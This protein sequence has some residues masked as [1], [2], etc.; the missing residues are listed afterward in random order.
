MS[1]RGLSARL[2]AAIM[3]S[4]LLLTLATV[5]VVQLAGGIMPLLDIL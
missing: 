2:V 5:S 4:V 1:P 3:I